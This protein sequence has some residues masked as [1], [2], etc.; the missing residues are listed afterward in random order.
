VYNI[1]P[2]NVLSARRASTKYLAIV[3]QSAE[4]KHNPRAQ[5]NNGVYTVDSF[6]LAV[7]AEFKRALSLGTIESKFN[8]VV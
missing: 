8:C 4:Q 5:H 7:N 2:W 6:S 3:R 1:E